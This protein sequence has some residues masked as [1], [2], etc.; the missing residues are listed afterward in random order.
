MQSKRYLSSPTGQAAE[1][2]H[3]LWIKTVSA[4]TS[5]FST[6]KNTAR[7][8]DFFGRMMNPDNISHFILPNRLPRTQ[9]FFID[10]IRT[11]SREVIHQF[12]F[13]IVNALHQSPH[14]VLFLLL[15][16]FLAIHIFPSCFL[17]YSI[18]KRNVVICIL[19]SNELN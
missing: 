15:F 18:I 8:E 7:N 4:L 9:H 19:Q 5:F 6:K 13:T 11:T 12:L 10:Y 1:S 17:C 3:H 2:S 14:F 16:N